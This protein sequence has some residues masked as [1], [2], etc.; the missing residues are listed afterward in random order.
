MSLE[1]FKT[2]VLLLHSEQRTLD[3]LSKGLNDRYSVHC[4]TSGTE[5]LNALGDTPIDVLVCAQNMPG[6]SGLEALREA[7]KRSPDM[8][9]ILLAGPD[10]SDGLEAMVG[11][12]EVFQ[13]I[14]G[15]VK[16]GDLQNSVDAATKSVRL[17]GISKSA[18]DTTANVDVAT[19]EHIV[20][21]TAPNGSA[22]VSDG[23]GIMP[24][25]KPERI[26]MAP[27]V[28]GRQIDILVLTKDEEFLATIK[29]SS[30]G[31]HDI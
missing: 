29:K 5:A 8:V 7:K 28:R 6:M 14:R 20:M 4:A 15:E 27:N 1:Q 3:L 11:E 2:Q 24:A 13:I 10:S 23:T 17:M 18:N 16:A 9:G 25:L 26:Q 30:M 19:A 21:E 22:I 12:Q 31:L